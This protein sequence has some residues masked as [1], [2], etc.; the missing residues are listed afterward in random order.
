M[1]RTVLSEIEHY[2]DAGKFFRTEICKGDNWRKLLMCL[3]PGQSVPSHRHEGYDV[4]LE[5]VRG[6]AEIALDGETIQLRA[7]EIVCADGSNDFAPHNRADENF[8]MLI[9]LVRR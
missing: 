1:K 9:T 6:T 4:L 2:N 8:A 5:P 7:G 3:A